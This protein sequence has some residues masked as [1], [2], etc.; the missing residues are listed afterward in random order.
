MR[1]YRIANPWKD[2]RSWV[3][4]LDSATYWLTARL[5]VP[6]PD[7]SLNSS[8]SLI[9][10]PLKSLAGI[11]CPFCGLTA[12]SIWFAHGQLLEGWG[13]NIL[14]PIFMMAAALLGGYTLIFRFIAGRGLDMELKFKTYLILWILSAIL[15]LASWLINIL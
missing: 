1:F 13:S 10:C 2:A 8:I 5:V 7:G 11:P 4:L 6:M 3:Y 9:S 15:T 14:S 12:R